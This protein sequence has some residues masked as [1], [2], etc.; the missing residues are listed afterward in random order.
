[1]TQ[2]NPGIASVVN[3]AAWLAHRYDPV[4]DKVHFI[5]ADRA[6][7][8]EAAFLTD[9]YLAGTDRPVVIDRREAVAAQDVRAPLH[10]IFHSAYCCSTLLANAFDIE[11]VSF[12]VKEPVILNDLSGWRRRG[13]EPQEVGSALQSALS[14]LARPFVQ[15]EHVIVKP[16]NVVNS[17]APAMMTASPGSRALLLYTP[18]PNYLGS[19]ARKGMWGRLW[20]RDLF[21][22]LTKDGVAD[23]GFSPEEILQQTDLQIAA[24]GW[25]AQHRLF[26][27]MAERFGPKR[28]RTLQAERLVADPAGVLA[29]LATH[30]GIDADAAKVEAVARGGAFDTDAKTGA[31]F[32]ASMRQNAHRDDIAVH[33]DEVGKVAQWAYAVA[34]AARQPMELPAP[35]T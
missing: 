17:L 26:A 35:L 30:F 20:V 7:Q 3:D 32:D 25:L 34:E 5:A 13:G 31:N 24:I 10:F 33:G 22:K 2:G 21:V 1:M 18:L 14:L 6:R 15:G 19:I 8:R 27:T 16:S 11:G 23:Y 28:I 9:E 4:R 29:A 12:G